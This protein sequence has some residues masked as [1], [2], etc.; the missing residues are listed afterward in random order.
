[1][2]SRSATSLTLFG[3]N[4]ERAD[5]LARILG[6]HV[7]LA[8]DRTDEPG[9]GFWVRFMELAGW[10]GSDTGRRDPAIEMGV[11]GSPGPP[12]LATIA[13]APLPAPAVPPPPPP[14][15]S[16]PPHHL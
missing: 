3:R 1:M 8:L 6:V 11:A 14:A 5:H 2:L 13:A 7:S 15:P 10:R 16:H 12:A 9:P 4:M